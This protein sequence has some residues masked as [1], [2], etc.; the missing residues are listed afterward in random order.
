MAQISYLILPEILPYYQRRQ[1]SVC[2]PWWESKP[3]PSFSPQKLKKNLSFHVC[4][5]PPEC[6]CGPLRIRHVGGGAAE[7]RRSESWCA[8]KPFCNETAKATRSFG[9]HCVGNNRNKV[10]TCFQNVNF[11]TFLLCQTFTLALRVAIINLK[12]NWL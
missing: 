10:N 9:K 8:I 7:S 11:G 2:Y 4:F 3:R 12:L 1:K 6:C 5:P